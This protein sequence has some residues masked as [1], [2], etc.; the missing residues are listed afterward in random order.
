MG[1]GFASPGMASVG[2][3]DILLCIGRTAENC[4]DRNAE[5]TRRVR[6]RGQ[7]ALPRQSRYDQ[8]FDARP[9]R[10]SGF[11]RPLS[12]VHISPAWTECAL[13]TNN[14]VT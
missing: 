1:G 12:M 9:E 7:L 13:D 6:A 3:A 14:D 11:P 4:V 2:A 8:Y 10:V 5:S